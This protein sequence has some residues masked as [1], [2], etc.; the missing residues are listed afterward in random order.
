MG[1]DG[2]TQKQL[3]A[4]K[5][6]DDIVR[7]G[8]GASSGSR[9]SIDRWAAAPEQRGQPAPAAALRAAALLPMGAWRCSPISRLATCDGPQLPPP[10]A[11]QPFLGMSLSRASNGRPMPWNWRQPVWRSRTRR[12][13]C[14]WR[15]SPLRSGGASLPPGT[16]ARAGASPCPRRHRPSPGG[17]PGPAMLTGIRGRRACCWGNC[18]RKASGRTRGAGALLRGRHG[19]S[20]LL[21]HSGLTPPS[22]AAWPGLLAQRNSGVFPWRVSEGRG[23]SD[24]LA[25]FWH[26]R[27]QAAYAHPGII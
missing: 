18:T 12:L 1:P 22:A 19:F 10:S 26:A 23:S 17:K 11:G 2:L 25:A 6:R 7:A 14:D 20:A 15:V 4:A 24:Y 27:L 9:R 5:G 21:L 13:V 16:D 3:T 8:T